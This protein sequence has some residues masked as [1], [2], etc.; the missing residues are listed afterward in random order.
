MADDTEDIR[1][2]FRKAAEKAAGE[3]DAELADEISALNERTTVDLEELKPQVS[4][5]ESY[6]KLIAAVEESTAKNESV[7]QLQ[8]RLIGLGKGVVKVA[9]EAAKLLT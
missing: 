6:D 9:K 7:A 8:T 3:T 5:P 1:A 4:D 2:R